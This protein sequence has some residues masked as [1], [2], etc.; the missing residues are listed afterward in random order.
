MEETANVI[1]FQ[2][3]ARDVFNDSPLELVITLEKNTENWLSRS[4]RLK[5]Y[6]FTVKAEKLFWT[7]KGAHIDGYKNKE[8][9]VENRRK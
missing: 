2:S 7:L 4:I 8:T 5:A 3:N 1:Y 9:E 6:K